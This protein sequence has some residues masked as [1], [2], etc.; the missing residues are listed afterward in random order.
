MS[1]TDVFAEIP[2]P[3]CSPYIFLSD[4]G[5]QENLGLLPLLQRRCRLI[6]SSDAGA[7]QSRTLESL[8]NALNLAEKLGYQFKCKHVDDLALTN[9]STLA[10]TTGSHVRPACFSVRTPDSIIQYR[11]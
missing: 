11:R 10:Q 1:F 2:L 3:E 8:E 6:I 9:V 4:G 5:H 7:D